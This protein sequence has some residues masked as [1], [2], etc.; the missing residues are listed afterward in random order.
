MGDAERDAEIAVEAANEEWI[1]QGADAEEAE[2]NASN[3]GASLSVLSSWD[4]RTWHVGQKVRPRFFGP[5]VPPRSVRDG[6]VVGF[7]SAGIAMVSWDGSPP[8]NERTDDL[9]VG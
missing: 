6:V 2:A 4:G 8:R 7:V 3:E 9:E 5:F 1:R